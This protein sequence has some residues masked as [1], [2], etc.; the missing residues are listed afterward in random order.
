MI[1]TVPDV[2]LVAVVN[3]NVPASS[4]ISSVASAQV[5]A[6]PSAAPAATAIN[7]PPV[8]IVTDPVVSGSEASMSVEPS[9]PVEE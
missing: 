5:F 7:P 4:S 9:A 3:R 8:P 6:V 1:V 2:V